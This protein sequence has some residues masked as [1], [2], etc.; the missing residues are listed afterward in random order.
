MVRP[1]PSTHVR[2]RSEKKED[3]SNKEKKQLYYDA[4]DMDPSNAG[5]GIQY[6]ERSSGVSTKP[7]VRLPVWTLRVGWQP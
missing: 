7:Q 4:V 1:T 3:L 6:Q 2:Y 5:G